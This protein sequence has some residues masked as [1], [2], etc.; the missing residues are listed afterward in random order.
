MENRNILLNR[1]KARHILTK[2][3][4]KFSSKEKYGEEEE[5]LK[6]YPDDFQEL[7]NNGFYDEY[8]E[9]KLYKMCADYISGMTDL[10]AMKLYS[11]MFETANISDLSPF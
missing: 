8:N 3:F 2:L 6:L 7:Y 11:A 1:N 10:Y 4:D 9:D 5:T